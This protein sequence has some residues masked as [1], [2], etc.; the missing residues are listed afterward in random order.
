MAGAVEDLD[1][2]C[3]W[4]RY[5]PRDVPSISSQRLYRADDAKGVSGMLAVRLRD[6]CASGFCGLS[7]IGGAFGVE[8]EGVAVLTGVGAVRALMD[9]RGARHGQ[10]QYKESP[11]S[12]AGA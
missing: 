7:K 12:A 10:Q 2:G 8:P 4:A 11:R 5:P 3:S 1:L 9:D 6:S